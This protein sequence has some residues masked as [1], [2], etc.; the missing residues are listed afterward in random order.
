MFGS[1]VSCFS[2]SR[3]IIVNK[4]EGKI[5]N[6]LFHVLHVDLDFWG[7]AVMEALAARD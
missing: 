7:Q 5:F 2:G 6:H 4:N 1:C 3:E